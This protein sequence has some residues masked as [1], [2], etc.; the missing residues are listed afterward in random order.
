[1]ENPNPATNK[2]SP[3]ESQTPQQKARMSRANKQTLALAITSTLLSSQTTNTHDHQSDLASGVS[4][5][6]TVLHPDFGSQ[7][8]LRR[9]C[10]NL[11]AHERVP[12]ARFRDRVGSGRTSVFAVRFPAGR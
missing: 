12:V 2:L 5:P 10:P 4:F 9:V 3:K 11:G 7:V 6:F 8:R 1:M